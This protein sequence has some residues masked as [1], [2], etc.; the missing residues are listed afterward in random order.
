ME[1][2]FKVHSNFLDVKGKPSLLIALA[3]LIEEAGEVCE[4][5]AAQQGSATK[6]AK[7]KKKNQTIDE[8]L[9]EELCDV[10]VSTLTFI[11]SFDIDVELVFNEAIKKMKYRTAKIASEKSGKK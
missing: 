7:I 5:L 3:K 9:V 1:E 4:V 11:R 8:A 6:A 2:L 10:V